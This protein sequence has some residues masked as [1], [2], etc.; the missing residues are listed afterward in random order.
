MT[1]GAAIEDIKRNFI[2]TLTALVRGARAINLTQADVKQATRAL[3]NL[4]TYFQDTRHWKEVWTSDIVKDTW[5][6]LWIEDM[7]NATPISE[8]LNTYRPTLS[9]LETSM[10]LWFRYLF[11][12]SIPIPEE[13]PAVFQASHHSPS[14]SYGIV[15]KIKRNC[16]LQIWDHAISWRETNLY[17]SSALCTLPPFTCNALLGLMRLTSMLTLHHADQI[18]PCAD[19]FNPGWEVEVGTSKGAITHRNTFRRK[20]DPVVNGIPPAD[21]KKFSPVK[22]IKTKQPT[23]TMLSHVW[24]AKDIKTALLA[25]DVILN[26]WGFDEYRLDIYGALNKA[27]IYSSE[28]TEVIAT[29]ALQSNV[30]L[31]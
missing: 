23:V 1:K 18:L 22:E 14:A 20:V 21:L 6:Q 24:F 3:V 12:F 30:S 9:D 29:K 28:C 5:R 10:D 15:C 8:W 2:P 16:T 11:I 27:P 26:K 13:I 17:L 7:P 4:N 19:Q 25:A 31:R